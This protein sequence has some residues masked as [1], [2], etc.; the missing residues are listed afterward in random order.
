MKEIKAIIQPFMLEKV[1]DALA[2]ADPPV[3]GLI[4]SQ[5]QGWGARHTRHDNSD[6]GHSFAAKTKVEIVVS[7]EQAPRI[8]TL[9]ATAARTGNPGDGK[10]FLVE[11]VDAVKVRTG[12]R[13]DAAL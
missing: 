7:D 8:A 11:V 1:L 5:V 4:I 6:C 10:V 9:I 2:G 12:D 13:G 3:P